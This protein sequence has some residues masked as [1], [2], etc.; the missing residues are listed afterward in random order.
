[1]RNRSL[2]T[3]LSSVLLL[4][5]L[6]SLTYAIPMTWNYTGV[7]TT[8]DCG[9]VPSVTGTLSGDSGSFGSN[10][11]I[12]EYL[13]LFGDLT[14]Y[15]F[16]IGSYHYSGTAADGTYLLDGSGNI[17]G[18]SMRFGGLLFEYIDAGS[19]TWTF[20]D[21]NIFARDV[22]ASGTGSY[23]TAMAVP[24]PGMLSLM[25]FGLVGLAFAVRRRRVA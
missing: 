1:M 2:V 6:P 11:E 5:A 16:T 25:G 18:G 8:G 17:V 23:T 4:L 3:R 15:S 12:N 19:A 7:C 22:R 13:F 14:S 21:D 10:N 20:N 24:E 9:V